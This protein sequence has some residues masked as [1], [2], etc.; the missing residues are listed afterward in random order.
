[1]RHAL[2]IDVEDWY[3][4]E[5]L[6]GVIDPSTWPQREARLDANVDRLLETFREHSVRATFFVL[7]AA[8]ERHPHAVRR[9]A[10]AGHEVGC[11]GWS[12]DLITRQDEATFRAETRR[13][14][15]LLEDLA[16][17]PVRGYR[18]ST[19]SIVERT[20]WALDVLADEGFEWDSSIAPVRHDRYGIPDCPPE[21]HVRRLADGRRITEFPVSFGRWFGLRVPIGGGYFRLL[22][23]R[24]TIAALS[25]CGERGLPG[26]IYL[27][28]WEFDP[29]QPR[30]D[31]LGWLPRFRHTVGLARSGGKLRRLLGAHAFAP[32]GEILAGW[33]GE[34]AS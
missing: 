12:H 34:A 4:V 6:R 32:M 8:A 13:S 22:P 5:N 33:D 7:G 20:L 26:S 29:G 10:A 9:I 30:V 18:A 16:Q 3:Q 17:V 2:T 19:F 25:S 27:H 14:K 24:W 21:P 31:G 1:M 15:A 28:P 23:A 11:H